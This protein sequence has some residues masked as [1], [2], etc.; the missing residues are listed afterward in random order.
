MTLGAEYLRPCQGVCPSKAFQGVEGRKGCRQISQGRELIVDKDIPRKHRVVGSL[1][2]WLKGQLSLRQRHY[3]YS[4]PCAIASTLFQLN[5]E[6][7]SIN[8][9]FLNNVQQEVCITLK[10]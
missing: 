9:I 7:E 3:F 6:I 8:L 2:R 5:I 1:G 4:Y 10:S